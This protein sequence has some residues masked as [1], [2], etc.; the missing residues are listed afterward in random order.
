[1][2]KRV[3]FVCTHN[4]ARSQTVGGR[5]CPL[6]PWIDTAFRAV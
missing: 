3:S 2:R 1:V 6:F 4:A 5:I